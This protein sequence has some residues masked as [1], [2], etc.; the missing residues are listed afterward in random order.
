MMQLPLSLEDRPNQEYQIFQIFW[1]VSLVITLQAWIAIFPPPSSAFRSDSWL[2]SIGFMAIYGILYYFLSIL[3]HELGH[4]TLGWWNGF[5]MMSFGIDRWVWVRRGKRFKLCKTRQRYA[6]GFVQSI[7]NSLD[8]LERRLFMMVLGGPLASFLLF[9]LGLV[10]LLFP[11]LVSKNIVAWGI[12]FC[13]VWNLHMAIV[14]VLPLRIG[15][16]SLDGRRMFDLAQNNLQSQRFAGFHRFNTCLKM[17]IRPRDIDETII[18][19]VLAIPER[20]FDHIAGLLLAYHVALDRGETEQAGTYLDQA[21]EMN[22]LY[23]E[24]FCGSLLLEGAYFEA[25]LRQRADLARQWWEKIPDKAL[26]APYALLRA[27]AAVLLAEGRKDEALDRVER[28][29]VSLQSD[30]FILGDAIVESEQLLELLQK[31]SLDMH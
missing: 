19:R 3:V 12:L 4:L 26:I 24:A 31:I 22:S 9:C 27:E 10:P 20:S 2:F 25:H 7:S 30:R 13:S 14:N 23:P 5:E 29:L 17:G 15:Y 6:G 11:G 18:D 16:L 1:T 21:L 28:G 8:M